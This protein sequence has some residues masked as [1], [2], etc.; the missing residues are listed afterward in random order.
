MSLSNIFKLDDTFKCD[1]DYYIVLKKLGNGGSG[2]AYLCMCNS[3]MNKGCYFVVK[4]F[5]QIDRTDGLER[6]KKEIKFLSESQHPAIVKYYGQGIHKYKDKEYPFYIMEYM[7]NSLQNELNSGKLTLERTLLYTTQLLAALVY[8]KNNNVIHRDI[9]PENIFIN[10]KR[11]IL[12]DFGLIKYIND[13][14]SNINEDIEE[15]KQSVYLDI[16]N[17][18]AMP[19]MYRTPQLVRYMNEGAPLNYK[20][21]VFQLGISVILMLTGKHPIKK[22]EKISDEVILFNKIEVLLSDIKETTYGKSIV[23]MVINMMNSNEDKILTPEEILE[24]STKI[25]R[26]FL[27]SKEELEG[28]I[29][30]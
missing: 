29:I 3:G 17:G 12:G 4:I 13:K 23:G 9:K 2:A 10:G 18:D 21:D 16:S 15:L 5:Y 8:M 24:K 26:K 14:D 7:S 27:K 20:S 30:I 25:L 22:P 1:D 28:Q 6:F 19:F 11:A